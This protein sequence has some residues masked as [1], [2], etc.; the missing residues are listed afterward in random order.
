M[1]NTKRLT[2]KTLNFYI[3]KYCVYRQYTNLHLYFDQCISTTPVA[4]AHSQRWPFFLARGGHPRFCP[5]LGSIKAEKRIGIV[6]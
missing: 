3:L 5:V 2:Y 1:Q 6:V 4:Q